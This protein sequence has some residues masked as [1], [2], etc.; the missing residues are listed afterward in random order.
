MMMGR[1]MGN[2]T[3]RL[4]KVQAMSS[5]AASS[6]VTPLVVG[7]LVPVQE[8]PA[9]PLLSSLILSLPDVCASVRLPVAISNLT[10]VSVLQPC[11]EVNALRGTHMGAQRIDETPSSRRSSYVL[12]ALG[13]CG[14]V[15][16]WTAK[17]R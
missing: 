5:P 2:L 14:C 8:T 1:K 4:R 16:I 13:A 9:R 3:R 12:R 10:A 7:V 6:I 15:M 17:L 11:E